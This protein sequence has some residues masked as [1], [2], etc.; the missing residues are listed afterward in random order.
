ML[1]CRLR[2][3]PRLRVVL[4]PALIVPPVRGYNMGSKLPLLALSFA[5]GAVAG[6]VAYRAVGTAASQGRINTEDL[7]AGLSALGKAFSSGSFSG[8]R[9][10]MGAGRG[11]GGRGGF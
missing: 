2:C 8:V 9:G 11:M 4:L 10:M 3:R 7:K 1:S 5:A 6:F